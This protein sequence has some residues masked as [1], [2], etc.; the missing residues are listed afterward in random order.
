MCALQAELVDLLAQNGGLVL[1]DELEKFA[2]GDEARQQPADTAAQNA[3]VDDAA[4]RPTP[5]Y[6][7]ILDSVTRAASQTQD[8]TPGDAPTPGLGM[9][10]CA[11]RLH[12]MPLQSLLELKAVA[13]ELERHQPRQPPAPGP[14]DP[15]PDAVKQRPWA[16]SSPSTGTAAAPAIPPLSAGS[17]DVGP[18]HLL[19]AHVQ[20][21]AS[22]Q[23]LA[24][25]KRLDARLQCIHGRQK[26]DC[27]ECGGSSMCEHNRRRTM[28]KDCGGSRICPHQRD[29]SQCKDCGGASIC[30]HG[31][32]RSICKDCGG[33]SLCVHL[34]P[35]S[36]CKEC[37]GASICQHKRQRAL[38]KEC[39]GVSICV[40][41]RRKNRCKECGGTSICPHGR[42]KGKCKECKPALAARARQGYSPWQPLA[43]GLLRGGVQVKNEAGYRVGPLGPRS[44]AMAFPVQWHV[45]GLQVKPEAFAGSSGGSSLRALHPPIYT[46]AMPP[47]SRR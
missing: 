29:R 45:P 38:C 22:Q 33:S 19:G 43:P 27:A 21:D 14:P 3:A 7:G 20:R 26:R 25:K 8:N 4:L 10:E 35:K 9:E 44:H 24:G 47:P 1:L 23:E 13:L 2:A 17:Q 30:P 40:H 15:H 36:K 34:R 5:H 39:G 12:E 46:Y 11:K 6:L 32:R 31:R 28:C 16:S 18:A 42:I 37:G 41:Q